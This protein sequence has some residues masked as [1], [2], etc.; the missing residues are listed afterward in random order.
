LDIWP[1]DKA[2]TE[3]IRS[4]EWLA[5]VS[6]R[7]EVRAAADKQKAGAPASDEAAH[8]FVHSLASIYKDA[9]G[10]DPDEPRHDNVQDQWSG[11]FLDFAEIV[12]APVGPSRTR[13][14]IAGLIRRAVKFPKKNKGP[15]RRRR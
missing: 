12:F 5:A 14:A 6:A 15:R 8:T 3:A 4:L 13:S 1:I 9:T 10:L 2:F 11:S 7:A